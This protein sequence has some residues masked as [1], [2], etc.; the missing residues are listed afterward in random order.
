MITIVRGILAIALSA[1]LVAACG[2][3]DTDTSRDKAMEDAAAER[4]IDADVTLNEEGGQE[5]IA[6]NAGGGQVG[7]NLDL[8]AGFPADVRLPADWD[9]IAASS[10]LPGSH[11]LQALSEASSDDIIERIRARLSADGW[12][13]TASDSAAPGMARI[14]LA[15]DDRIA[16]FN[17]IENGGTRAIQIMVMPK[18]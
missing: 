3:S 16:N 14:S 9:I 6:I 18:P 11:N 2:G 10:P 4:G 1:G 17:I 5:R 8:P 7:R 12:A 13:E 15:K